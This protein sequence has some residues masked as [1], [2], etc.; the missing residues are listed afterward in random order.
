MIDDN[1]D[2]EPLRVNYPSN[3]NKAKN[4]EPISEEKQQK[5]E[6]IVKGNVKKQKRSFG[7]RMADIFLEDNTQNVSTYLV[8]DVLIPAGKAMICDIVGWGGFAEMLLFGGQGGRRR[9]GGTS[10]SIYRRDNQTN[11]NYGALSRSNTR[12][13][14]D[15]RPSMTRAGRAQHDF[16]Q[17]VLDSR[18]EAEDVLTRLIDL[19][20][21]EYGFASVA[22]LY[23]LVG[24]DSNFA[25]QK[26]G[27]SDL[28]TASVVR[29]RDGY[30]I[31]LPRTQPID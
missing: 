4:M 10:N 31:K 17:I 2:K 12:D 14:R 11:Y 22:D 16:S 15:N 24:M 5:V 7:Q 8:Q 19:T 9:S 3:S 28:R 25:D 1:K 23:D 13:P 21:S 18:G 6:K 29:V 20:E 26:Y 27:W 30:L